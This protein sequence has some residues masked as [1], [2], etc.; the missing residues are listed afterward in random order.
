MV[1]AIAGAVGRPGTRVKA[2]PWLPIGVAGV[3]RQTPRELYE[4]RYLWRTPIRLD[5]RKLVAFPG[6]EPHTKLEEA[7]RTTLAGL[8]VS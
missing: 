3:V 7:V 1:G 4:M 6:E 2:L 5:N 8:G